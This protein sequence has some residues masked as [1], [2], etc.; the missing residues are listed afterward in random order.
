MAV[1]EN[2]YPNITI[3]GN[4]TE[5]VKTFKYLGTTVNDSLGLQCEIKWRIDETR[6]TLLTFITLLCNQNLFFYNSLKNGKL[7]CVV[8]VVV[9]RGDLKLVLLRIL[10]IS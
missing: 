6:H 7:L 4:Q 2:N 3:E 10:Q 1:S 9:R 5:Q 8:D